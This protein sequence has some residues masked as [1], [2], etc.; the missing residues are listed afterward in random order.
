M[1]SQELNSFSSI[2]S[3]NPYNN[4]YIKGVSNFLNKEKSP[5]YMKEQ[6][7][8]SYLNTQ[9]YITNQIEI[10]KNI[11]EEDIFD[12]INIKVYDELGLDQAIEY[13]M[14]YIEIN[15]DLETEN[16]Y[17]QVFLVDP[18][19]LDEIF[20]KSVQTISYIDTITPSPLLIKSLY[21]KN[22]IQDNSTH[23]FIYFEQDDA[24]I[25]IYNKKEFIY[26]KSLE[27][28]LSQMYD[29]FCELYGERV[30]YSEFIN[31]LSQ[32]NLKYTDS[33][34]KEFV[35]KLYKEIF[36]NITN[37][38]TYAKKA[39]SIEK[40]S[41][42]YIG[43]QIS[44]ASKLYEISEVEL[45]VESSDFSFDYGL[46]T[47]GEYIN[48][49]HSLLHITIRLEDDEKYLCD[50]ST[51]NRPPKFSKRESGKI[52]ILVIASLFLAFA[53]PVTY[54][55]LA[56]TQEIQYELLSNEYNS[57]HKVKS[58]RQA[59]IKSKEAQRE[60]SLALLKDE[61][62]QYTEKKNTLK[63]IHDVKVNYPMKAK[64]IYQ[65]TQ[66]LNK[67]SIK[68]KSVL[69]SQKKDNKNLT[70]GL[71]SSKDKKITE[72]LEYLTKKYDGKFKFFLKEIS[73]NKEEKLYLSQ[74]KV[75]IL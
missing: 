12:T 30:E 52:F 49:I 28:S 15:S 5:S 37:I 16:R 72:L 14:Q 29:R 51:Y 11:P 7:V 73:Y 50:F 22:L 9:A 69:Y 36:T 47:N 26:T 59:L 27:H 39:F 75:S 34:Y 35:L 33:P 48:Q 20:Q 56:Y 19:E 13:Q 44:L 8:S 10:S 6:Y 43:T 62:K 45:G 23:S 63:K 1:S 58:T 3:V 60:K 32:E 74:L 67:F 2:L 4:E 61:N 24:F 68:I 42:V 21:S 65:M 66:D 71:T 38:L 55:S 31:F 64:L 57:L 53:Y 70:L 18:Q 17:F 25:A 54:L 41:H 46:E 40:V